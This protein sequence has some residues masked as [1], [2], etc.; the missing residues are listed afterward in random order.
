MQKRRRSKGMRPSPYSG[1]LPAVQKVLSSKH[2]YDEDEAFS[3]VEARVWPKGPT[4]PRCSA[5]DRI[6]KLGGGMTRMRLYKCY[7]CRKPFGVR[8]GTLFQSSRIPLHIWL[9]AIYLVAGSKRGISAR[10]L[11]DRLDLTVV[12]A[13]S[14][15]RRIRDTMKKGDLAPFGHGESPL[16]R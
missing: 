11:A 16:P 12:S 5:T 14:V 13:W 10:R 1:E 6:G 7:W 8:T 4:C 3:F 9:Q 2:F 15:S